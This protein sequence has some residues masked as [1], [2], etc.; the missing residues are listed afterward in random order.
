MDD[1]HKV[2]FDCIQAMGEN[3]GDEAGLDSCR[4]SIRDHFR[5]EENRI[6]Q[7]SRMDEDYCIRHTEKHMRFVDFLK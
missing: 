1:Q 2:L 4:T 7:H 5:D 3:P 6:C